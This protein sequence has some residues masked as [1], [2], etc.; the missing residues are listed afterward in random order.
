MLHDQ[1]SDLHYT[2]MYLSLY[3]FLIR[4]S[5]TIKQ[6]LCTM[7]KERRTRKVRATPKLNLGKISYKLRQ[8]IETPL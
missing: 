2:Y 8:Q 4:T 1:L 7:I 5:W 3:L 6:L